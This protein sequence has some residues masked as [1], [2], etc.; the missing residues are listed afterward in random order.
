MVLGDIVDDDAAADGGPDGIDE[1]V[2]TAY[3]ATRAK[4]A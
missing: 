3:L 1:D 2:L 4:S